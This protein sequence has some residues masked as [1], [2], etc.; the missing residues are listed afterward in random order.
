MMMKGKTSVA[1]Q[2]EIFQEQNSVQLNRR[3]HGTPVQLIHVNGHSAIVLR[4]R[5][6]S[7]RSGPLCSNVF[8]LMFGKM[9]QAE[10]TSIS[11]Q[12]LMAAEPWLPSGYTKVQGE[13]L[14]S[15]SA[16]THIRVMLEE[17]DS[18]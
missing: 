11:V 14:A 4:R 17:P 2:K 15:C 8:L 13:Y 1:L 5:H 18:E 12:A 7:D 6:F 10:K 3:A 9:N 16:L